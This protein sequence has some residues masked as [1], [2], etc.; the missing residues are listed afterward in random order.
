MDV[1]NVTQGA[2]FL[3][4]GPYHHHLALNVW[5]SKN[6]NPPAAG[7]TGLYHFAIRFSSR[8]ELAAVLKRLI[9]NDVVIESSS[10]AGGIVE[11]IYV[12]DPDNNGVEL[13]WDRPR[14]L[15]PAPKDRTERSLDLG[16][17]LAVLGQGQTDGS[18]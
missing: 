16:E 18:R 10:D 4:F 3:A 1:R 17:L 14:E 11:S 7:T 6:G 2:V 9:D 5:E 12:R 8:A 13:T 15:W